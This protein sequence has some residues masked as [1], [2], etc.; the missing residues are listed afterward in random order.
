MNAD[1][2][3]RKPLR[4]W[5]GVALAVIV[6]LGWY[7]VPVVAPDVLFYAVFGALGATVAIVVWWLIFSRAPWL[8]R[9]GAIAL[10]AA[11]LYVMRPLVHLSILT[12]AQGKMFLFLPLPPLALALVAWAAATRHL[13]AVP[14][15]AALLATVLLACAPWALL[16]IGGFSATMKIDYM[17]R[18]TPTPEER[19][20][21]QAVDEPAPAP[22]APPPSSV[23][24]APEPARK[25]KA[26]PAVAAE[27]PA[28][29]ADWPGFR[30]AGRDGIVHGVRIQTD[31]S[32]SPP[33]EMWRR[34]IGPGWSSFAADGDLLYTQEQ[35]GED[36]IVGCYRVSTGVPVWR[37]RDRVRFWEANAGAGPRATPTL[38]RGRVYT[39][40]ATGMLNAL[41]A[42]TGAV[43]WSRNA[44]TD[45]KAKVPGWGFAGSP[46]VVG[47]ALMVATAGTLAAYDLATGSPRWVGPKRPSDYSSPQLA[48]IDG[49]PQIL[50]L[51]GTGATSLALDDGKVLWEH[52][53][54]RGARIIQPALTPDGD[55]LAT[56]GEYGDGNGMRRIA[57]MR[58][59]AGWTSQERWTTTG[60]KPNFNDFVVHKGHVYGFDGSIL[61]CI[62]LADGTRKWKGGRYGNGQ[63]MLLADQDLLLVV[64]EEGEL[65][66]VKATP[67]QFTELGRF[68]AIEGKTWN[69]PALVHGVLLVRNG[70]EMAAFRLSL[71]EGGTQRAGSASQ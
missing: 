54:T 30:G 71:A 15:R 5:P 24:P 42:R 50:L 70:E 29:P 37:H 48:T 9:I 19:L 46:L 44:G 23:P 47:D 27:A 62:D 63:L 11:T 38:H 34:K 45:T 65:A 26:A 57:V 2:T 13:A 60:L 39:L 43:V 18:W 32:A 49:T 53:L 8:E 7:V 12:A 10:I 20:L 35:R 64:S 33:A 28:T 3:S 4:L 55:V 6:A 69:H 17:W 25:E 51:T 61:A 31:W 22:P 41:D 68:K 14:R 21:A 58:G 1:S 56:N 59:S 40:G 52:A 66:L 67:D 36:E 16:K